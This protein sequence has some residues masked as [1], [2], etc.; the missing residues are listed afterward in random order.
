M[1]VKGDKVPYPS[2]FLNAQKTVSLAPNFITILAPVSAIVNVP[3]GTTGT[4]SP[5]IQAA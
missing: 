3:W 1:K 4:A 5:G 2:F